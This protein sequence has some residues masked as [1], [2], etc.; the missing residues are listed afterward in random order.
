MPL[1]ADVIVIF[2]GLYS[3]I[4]GKENYVMFIYNTAITLLNYHLKYIILAQVD[5]KKFLR[6][7]STTKKIRKKVVCMI[8]GRTI[9]IKKIKKNNKKK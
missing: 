5:S 6:S 7:V 9:K 4:I 2:S 3:P 8:E 1:Q